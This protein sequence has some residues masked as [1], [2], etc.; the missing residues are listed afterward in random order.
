MNNLDTILPNLI[1]ASKNHLV[2]QPTADHR[3]AKSAFWTSIRVQ[4]VLPPGGRPN[5][6]AAL[7][8]AGDR[9]ISKW[10]EQDG[11]EEWFCNE[12][13]FSQRAEYIA[14]LALDQLEAIL[15]TTTTTNGDKIKAIQLAVQLANKITT[16]SKEQQFADQKIAGMD[17]KQLEEFITHQMRLLPQAAPK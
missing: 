6:A 17:A 10:W 8:Y 16:S 4:G 12:E 9:R 7:Q 13:E 2:F 15:T 14:S 11:F 1:Q 3:R 5:L